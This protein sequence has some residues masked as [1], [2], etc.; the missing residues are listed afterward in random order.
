MHKR[1]ILAA[2]VAVSFLLPAA[3]DARAAEPV[4]ASALTEPVS[5]I[6]GSLVLVGGGGLPNP[7][8]ERFLELGGGKHARLVVIPTASVKA[9]G[10]E[11]LKSFAFW[12]SQNVESCTLLHT[13]KPEM[14]N[15]PKF[16]RA[17]R[18]ATA[19]WLSGGDQSKLMAAYRGTGVERALHELLT[20]GGV[21]GG[22]SAGAAVMSSVMITG[23]NPKAEVDAGFGFL[24][25]A[26]VDQHLMKRNRVPRL[27][28]VLT[29]HP[30]YF[31]LGID[32][33]TAVVVQGRTLEVL[34]DA[35]VRIC[36]A[37]SGQQMAD[38]KVLKSGER[39]DLVSLSRMAVAR[40]RGLLPKEK[41]MEAVQAMK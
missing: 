11:P 39:A 12:K 34:G 13:R 38:V 1:Q 25:G 17:L 4:V 36:Y 2:L 30:G 18:E 29:S 27:L 19:V 28:G 20:R 8:L 40:A 33:Q 10:P 5:P 35:A 22:T 3:Q 32:E 24:P 21:I 31:G 26:V 16:L 14:A 15:D 41:P 9:D 23:G 37:A 6:S 7:I